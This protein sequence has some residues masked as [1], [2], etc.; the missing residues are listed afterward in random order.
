MNIDISTASRAKDVAKEMAMAA[1]TFLDALDEVQRAQATF[2]FQGTE[3][4][5]WHYTPVARNG[6]R[7]KD[8]NQ[9][10]R[11]AAHR[12]LATALSVRSAREAEAIIALEVTL[13]EWEHMQN[14]TMHW[15]RDPDL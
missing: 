15:V 12:L 1:R 6:L 14:E 13:N 7:L 3:R 5:E 11:E 10:Q 9:G 8:M 4:Y 2:P